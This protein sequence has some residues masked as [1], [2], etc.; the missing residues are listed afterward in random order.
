MDNLTKK[1]IHLV[2]SKH[3]SWTK[4][5]SILKADSR[6]NHIY[7]ENYFSSIFP[8]ENNPL[9]SLHDINIDKLLSE[10]AAQ[11]IHTITIFDDLYPERLKTI[12]QP[13]WVLFAKG[14][15]S[16]LKYEKSLAVVGAR[17]ATP[18]G[19]S[20]IEYLFPDLIMNQTLIISGLA[21]GIDTHAHSTA[22]KLGGKTAGVI[23]GGFNNIYPKENMKLARYMMDHQLVISEYPPSEHPVKWQ[24]PMRN[25]II[26]GLS[27]GT[28]VV[29]ARKKSGSLITADYALNEGREVFAVP[30]SILNHNSDGVHDLIQQGAKLIKSSQEILEE[31]IF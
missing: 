4:I 31:L 18:Y 3:S 16:L 23:A 7:E 25:R 1:L 5:F 10:Y 29:E 19:L 6:M 8:Q 2:H 11:N 13:P 14:D 21:R 24:F 27:K 9:N 30:G 12:Y 22:I 15:T 26:S 20:A 17:E 28:L